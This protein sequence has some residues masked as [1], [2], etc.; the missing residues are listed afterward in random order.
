MNR[1]LKVFSLIA[2]IAVFASCNKDD[3]TKTAPPRDYTVQNAADT[4]SINKF[5][6]THYIVLDETTLQATFPEIPAGSSELSIREQQVYPLDSTMVHRND[7]DYKV[8]YLT[9]REG[10]S[11]APCGVDNVNVNYRGTLLDGT[12]FDYA[13]VVGATVLSL[14]ETVAGWQDIFPFFKSGTY[15]GGTEG[16]P[17]AFADFGAGAMFLP[18]G[19]GYYNGSRTN[20]PAYSCLVFSFQLFDVTYT[21]LDGDKI[22]NKDEFEINDETGERIA[23]VFSDTDGDGIPNYA[24][25]DDDGDGFFTKDELRKLIPDPNNPGQYIPSPTEYYTYDEMFNEDGTIKGEFKCPNTIRKN[26][27]VPKYMD[28]TCRGGVQ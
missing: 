23:V 27:F 28:D 20:L 24:D 9:F 19:L 7:I 2:I 15:L 8:Y 25:V 6:N 18:S 4:D 13:P 10:V 22:L 1:F 3:D 14:N 11:D 5:L 16:D 17:A 26:Y 12:Q 21:D